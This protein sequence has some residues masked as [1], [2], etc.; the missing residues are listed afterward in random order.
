MFSVAAVG[1]VWLRMSVA[2]EA[3]G[4]VSCFSRQGMRGHTIIG[5]SPVNEAQCRRQRVQCPWNY[6]VVGAPVALLVVVWGRAVLTPPHPWQRAVVA[7]SA[8]A[9][10]GS[11]AEAHPW[12]M[13]YA[14]GMPPRS[15]VP[16]ARADIATIQ[17]ESWGWWA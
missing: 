14:A 1:R 5:I 11:P 3:R 2:V 10:L 4:A 7:Q 16:C 8:Q 15:P 13:A 9:C 17:W 6:N 12:H